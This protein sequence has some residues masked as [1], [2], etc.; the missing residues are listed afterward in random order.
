MSDPTQEQVNALIQAYGLPSSQSAVLCAEGI[1]VERIREDAEKYGE[2]K[3]IIE[4]YWKL[5]PVIDGLRAERERLMEAASNLEQSAAI[6]RALI[7]CIERDTDVIEADRA[8]AQMAWIK[9]VEGC[10][11]NERKAAILRTDGKTYTEIADRLPHKKGKR[12]TPEGV[13]KMLLRFERKTKQPGLFA[14][15]TYRQNV[16]SSE[17]PNDA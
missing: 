12:M 7:R 3:G 16:L 10:S 14:R 5:Q 8:K 1:P 11:E 13:R 2:A 17:R 6:A 15:G 9:K 4:T